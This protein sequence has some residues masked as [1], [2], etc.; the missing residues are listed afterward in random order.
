MATA[1]TPARERG[2]PANPDA[3]RAVL[4]AILLDDIAF[5]QAAQFGLKAD[6]FSLDANRRIYACMQE[7]VDSSRP[8]E[9]VT[10]CNRLA[11]HKLLESVG[12]AAYV[13]SLSDGLP[14]RPNIESYVQIVRDKSTLRSIIF[15]AN[16][17]IDRAY[18]QSEGADDVLASVEGSLFQIAQR[19]FN[20]GLASIADI[21][22][23]SFGS[24]DAFIN[25]AHSITGVETYFT[26]LDEKTSGLQPS[27]LIIVA[28]RPSM[29]K[30]AFAMNIAENTAVQG[31]KTVAVFSL[32][33]SRE[34]LLQRMVCSHARVDSHRFRT[35]FLG[36]EDLQKVI[37]AAGQ[38]MEARIF[39]D[40]TPGITVG[41]MR[42][43]ARRLQH[44]AGLDLL[45]VDY[46][47]L[48]TGHTPL[49]KSYENRTQEVSA[50][51]RGLKLVAKDLK[52]PV[53]ALSQLSRAPE[54][55]GDKN[56][57]HRPLL[58][59]LRESGSIEQDADVVCF[60]YRPEVY[61]PENVELT[62]RAEIIIAKQ[63]N[64][65]IGKVKLA[66]SHASTRFDN[67]ATEDYGH[68]D[69]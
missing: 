9:L 68:E 33:M 54:T 34:A 57:G 10:L 50:I 44:Q 6:D 4:G 58:S 29:G 62:G 51:S 22:K 14:R 39:I 2:L 63:R 43:K 35:G 38:L 41:E 7:M 65:P 20:Q 55:R 47:Q 16:E 61:D 46:L 15:A 19:R 40:D 36:K 8:L 42:A 28:G 23:N 25:R 37:H 17:A 48:I 53:V 56:N 27:D 21:F 64:G 32:E 3:E 12:G 24:L 30:T 13:A 67:L 66:F 45:I 60:V 1:T 5:T 52:V 69:D 59:D 11:E 31:K 26:R 49:G 18:D